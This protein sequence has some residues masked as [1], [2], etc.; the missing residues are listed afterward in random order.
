MPKSVFDLTQDQYEGRVGWAPTNGS[1]QSF[2]TAMRLEHGDERTLEWLENMRDNEAVVFSNNSSQVQGIADGEIDFGLVNN[3][4]LLRFLEEDSDFP[5]E[6]T[7]FEQGDIGNLVNVAGV[8]VLESSD[9]KQNAVEF[10]RY[11]LSPEAQQYFTNNVYEYPVIENVQ[12]N[13]E[14]ESIDH[15]MEV[16]PDV[17][18]DNLDDLKGTL[19]LLRQAE[20]L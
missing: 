20:L 1:F 15:L 16:S 10:V 6:Q 3:Y 9:D 11:L 17:A 14:L 5:V 13:D 18:L 2:V 4:Y 7:F 12:Q 19:D 8:G